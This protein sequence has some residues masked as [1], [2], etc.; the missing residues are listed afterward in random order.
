[1]ILFVK[2]LNKNMILK[3]KTWYSYYIRN[4]DNI[5]ITFNIVIINLLEIYLKF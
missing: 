5:N 2:L 1:M 3:I 4:M